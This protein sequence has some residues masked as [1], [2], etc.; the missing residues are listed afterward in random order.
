M[1]YY[2]VVRAF[3]E[4]C[5]VERNRSAHTIETY[6][7][8]LD[9]FADY[10]RE[11]DIDA[12]SIETITTAD[13]RPFLGHLHDKGLTAKTLRLKIAAVKSLFRF[14]LKRDFVT[15]NPTLLIPSP[16]QEKKLPSF[17][18]PAEVERLMAS[19]DTSTPEGTRDAAIA[20]LLYSSG[21]RVSELTSLGVHSIAPDD[22][23]V[24]VVG[25]GRKERIVP[26]GAKAVES[27]KR[28]LAVRSQLVQ[29]G[30]SGS[31][32][33]LSNRGKPLSPAGVYRIIHNALAPVTEAEQKSP[34]VLRHT[35]ATHL[36]DNGADIRAVSEMLG[37][38]S[39]STTQIYTHVSV[40]RLKNI[41][42]KAHPKG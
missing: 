23:Q 25:K 22:H 4:Y 35:F 8:A 13:I 28:Y 9:Q 10:M 37:H 26:V 12:G 16:R 36:L 5:E 31:A 1:Q 17:L 18:Q 34:H 42:K 32:L 3:L 29:P 14:C 27:L 33:F 6:R 21:L 38:S 15:S 39:L 19:F 20:E 7:L 41:Y 2:Q 24:R 40:E 11:M 30:V